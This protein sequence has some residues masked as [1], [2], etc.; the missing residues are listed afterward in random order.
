MTIAHT[1]HS[2]M[3]RKDRIL[4]AVFY[5]LIALMALICV[6]PIWMCFAVA[7]SDNT[8]IVQNGYA[9]I[10]QSL[11]TDTFRYLFAERWKQLSRAFALS[12]GTTVFGTVIAVFVTVCFAYAVSQRR[13]RG[14]QVLSFIAYFTMLF[15]GGMLAWYIVCTRYL[16]LGNSFWGL[17]IPSCFS[18][19]NMY[20]MRNYFKGIPEELQE[21]AFVDG[22]GV[23]R[24]FFQI[25]LPL[26]KVGMITI[27]LFYGIGYWNDFYL[28]LMLSSKD[29]WYTTQY[30]LYRMMSN[31]SFLV[32]QGGSASR[33]STGIQPPTETAR[34]AMA[35]IAVGPIVIVYPFIQKYFTK[36]VILGALKG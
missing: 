13:F 26:S 2:L 4:M 30:L 12:I 27:A 8:E 21:A 33:I 35:V 32:T 20:L 3:T 23:F 31:I 24:T 19:F 22:A 29:K 1:H 18:V 5:L 7:F 28:P 10:P 25:M 34:M 14:G 17:T 36:G 9:L 16:H 15:N 11:T 6:I